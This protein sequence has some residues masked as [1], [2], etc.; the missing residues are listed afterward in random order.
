MN[1]L[2]RFETDTPVR[3]DIMDRMCA[4]VEARDTDLQEQI[5]VLTVDNIPRDIYVS[6]TGNDTTGDGS[7]SLPYR[8][9]K[10]ALST[11]KKNIKAEIKIRILQGDYTSEGI[12]KLDNFRGTRLL[13][14]AFDGISDIATPSDNYMFERFMIYD[15]EAIYIQGI[16]CSPSTVSYGIYSSNSRFVRITGYKIDTTIGTSGLGCTGNSFVWVENSIAKNQSTVISANHGATVLSGSWDSSSVG[17]T[18]AF[19]IDNGSKVHKLD[20]NQPTATNPVTQ[21]VGG[22]LFDKVGSN[23]MTRS[24]R[25]TVT[26]A[27]LSNWTNIAGDTQIKFF[28]DGYFVITG[29]ITGGDTSAYTAIVQLPQEFNYLEV[30]EKPVYNYMSPQ[31]AVGAIYIQNKQLKIDVVTSNSRIDLVYEGRWY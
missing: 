24:L 12:V 9:L 23:V 28:N 16:K 31:N 29:I 3:Y 14:T 15:C 22:V 21:K 18:N 20:D 5:N 8:T 19:V 6:T 30:I 1:A 25:E 27:L 26:L 11:V 4:E 2:T 17:N 10:K 13:I 7:Q